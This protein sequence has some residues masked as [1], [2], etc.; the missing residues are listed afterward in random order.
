MAFDPT[1]FNNSQQ[2]GI[3]ADELNK[4]G[5]GIKDAHD[6]IDEIN[7]TL[8]DLTTLSLGEKFT[9]RYWRD[10]KKIYSNLIDFGTLPDTSTK[11]ISTG[12]DDLEHLTCPISG[13]TYKDNSIDSFPLP[14]VSTAGSQYFIDLCLTDD[15]K[16]RIRTGTDR[17]DM[18][19]YVVLKYT[20]TTD[21]VVSNE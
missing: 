11:E 1:V 8:S 2:P 20:K 14:F 10:G 5:T 9:G 7:D 12:V 6:S 17:S 15:N 18:K 13:W 21:E 4:F 19:A 3:S 16:V